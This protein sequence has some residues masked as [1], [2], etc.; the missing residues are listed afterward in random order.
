MQHIETLWIVCYKTPHETV[1]YLPRHIM[2]TF[3]DRESALSFLSGFRPGE[4]ELDRIMRISYWGHVDLFRV[5]WDN[6][7]TLKEIPKYNPDED[8]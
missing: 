8:H 1:S 3:E 5:E 7:L 2:K 6:G 4:K